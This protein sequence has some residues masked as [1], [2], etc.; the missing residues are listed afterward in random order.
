[1]AHDPLFEHSGA[2][3]DA[4][5]AVDW[6]ASPLGSVRGW[7]PVLR[8]AVGVLLDSRFPITL[9]WGPEFVLFYN[10][11]YVELIADK[12]PGALGARAQDVFPEAW[13][14]IGPWMR[15]ALTGEGA[16]W[17]ED[18]PVPL[19]RRGRLEEAFFT[20]CYAPVRGP[21]G[22]IEGV[23]DIASETTR[24]VVGRRRLRLLSTLRDV[25]SELHTVEDL[26]AQ[27]LPVLR[28]EADDLPE[29]QLRITADARPQ[30]VIAGPPHD[31]THAAYLRII[32]DLIAEGSR[33]VQERE[34]E[35]SMSETLQ[36]SL[37]PE[38]VQAPGAEVAVRYLPAAVAASVGGDWYD[39]FL[40]PDGR[41]VLAIGDVTGHDRNA[42]AAMAQVRNLLRGV[43]HAVD[44][45]PGGS[46]ERLDAAML[47][48][49]VG[50]LATAVVAR[51]E[52]STLR[53]ANAGHPPPVLVDPDG[54]ARLLRTAPE[55]LLG[56]IRRDRSDHVAELAPGSSVLFYTDGLVERRGASIDAGMDWLVER[57]DGHA[58]TSADALCDHVLA[59]LGD[60]LED[61][62]AL[63]ALHVAR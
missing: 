21:D 41:L 28:T 32:V 51:L 7:S 14:V 43:C 57:S 39:S 36:R 9:L 49:E 54:H 35:R 40:G 31:A 33:R 44:L 19:Q 58:F 59:P 2:L 5:A 61:D 34:D 15:Q 63:L 37:L 4:Y 52:G 3:R 22:T 10:E 48:L 46:L 8:N 6:E 47:G 42:A 20:F 27:V 16:T 11:A 12:H 45:T 50:V 26:H 29:V 17:I 55:T 1:M 18:A 24:A 56:L 13:D 23:M 38:P 62:V 60:D 30:L 25:L 53:F